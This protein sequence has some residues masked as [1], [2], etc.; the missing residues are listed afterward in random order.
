MITLLWFLLTFFVFILVLLLARALYLQ[1][2]WHQSVFLAGGKPGRLEGFHKGSAGGYADGWRGK[3][4]NS[5]TMTGDN[6]MRRNGKDKHI[7]PFKT[8]EGIGIIDPVRVLKIDYNV[9]GNP[10]WLRQLLDELTQTGKKK[11]TGKLFFRPLKL[12]LAF[13]TLEKK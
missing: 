5:R 7:Y 9:P 8:W 3:H 1:S 6:I 4:F 10:W 2:S 13:F 11:F 12:P